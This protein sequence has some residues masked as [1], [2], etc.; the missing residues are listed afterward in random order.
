MDSIAVGGETFVTAPREK[1]GFQEKGREVAGG[2]GSYE[3]R[4]SLLRLQGH[5]G[6]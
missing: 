5:F 3:L 4:G 6:A 2:E 1:L